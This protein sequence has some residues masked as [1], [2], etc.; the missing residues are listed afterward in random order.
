VAVKQEVLK[1]VEVEK[2]VERNV[3]TIKQVHAGPERIVPVHVDRIVEVP[4]LVNVPQV[5]PDRSR[6]VFSILSSDLAIARIGF[7]ERAFA[8]AHVLCCCFRYA[9]CRF[10]SIATDK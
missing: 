7:A 8:G 10:Q 2:I 9:R 3:E 4:I 5:P 6:D 1:T